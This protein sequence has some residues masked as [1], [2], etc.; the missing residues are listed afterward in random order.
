MFN[1]TSK[2]LVALTA[3]AAV[4]GF[5]V[6]RTEAPASWWTAGLENYT[7]YHTRYLALGCEYKH[8][9][10]FFD[11]C[12]H[13]LK[14]NETLQANRPAQCTPSAS[15][16]ASAASAEPTS[17]VSTPPTDT[18][19][20]GDEDCDDSGDDSE[21]SSVSASASEK[22][23]STFVSTSSPASSSSWSS[24]SSAWTPTSTSSSWSATSSS[25]SSKHTSPAQSSSTKTSSASS[26]TGTS[27]SGGSPITGGFATFFLQNGV[28]GACDVV[29]QDSDLIAAIDSQRYGDTSVASALCGKQAKITNTDNGKSVVVTIADACPTCENSNCMDLSKGAFDQIADESTGEVPSTYTLIIFT[30]KFA[31]LIVSAVSWE[32]V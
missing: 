13:P 12:C 29:H 23:S 19:D 24:S 28:A 27:S 20:D 32:F 21:S 8:G 7:V 6:P 31:K 15:S 26:S 16:S 30:T 1:F 17:T 22:P 14:K 4:S 18:E 10:T 3:V 9:Q 25:H 5:V 2:T 11:Q